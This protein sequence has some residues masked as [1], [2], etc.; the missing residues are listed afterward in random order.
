M[1][2]ILN[3]N[4]NTP[5]I[6]EDCFIAPSAT[7]VGE[8]LMG[9]ECSIWFNAVI[10]GDVNSIKI[11]RCVNIQDNVVVHCTYKKYSTTIGNHVSIGHNAIIHGC[12][13]H[14][15]VLIGMGSVVMNHASIGKNCIIG[16]N[17]LITERKEFPDNSLIMGSPAKVIRQLTEEEIEVLALSAHHYSEKAKIY[18]ADLKS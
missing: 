9:N 18:K 3:L 15:N 16:A 4:G 13:I 5:N 17:S 2:T 7:I 11:G 10:R 6:P 8:V 12:K 1:A 14:D